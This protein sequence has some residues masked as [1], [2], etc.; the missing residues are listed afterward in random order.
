MKEI[1]GS[2]IGNRWGNANQWAHSAM[3]NGLLVTSTP[4][5]G[6]I[7]VFGGGVHGAHGVFGHVSMVI[8]V[9]GDGTIRVRGMNGPGGPGVVYERNV[10][11]SGLQFIHA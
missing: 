2:R 3:I 4:A 9:N 5:V 10:P 1:F 7:A 8:A 11:A 6:T